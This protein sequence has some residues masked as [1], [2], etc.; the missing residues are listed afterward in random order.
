MPTDQSN[1]CNIVQCYHRYQ[2]AIITEMISLSKELHTMTIGNIF[3][4]QSSAHEILQET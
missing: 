1:D 3:K 2:V 4:I